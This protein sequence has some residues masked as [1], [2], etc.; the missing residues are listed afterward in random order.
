MSYLIDEQKKTTTIQQK[1]QL[2]GNK[3]LLYLSS[4]RCTLFPMRY[5]ALFR[6]VRSSY[7][8]SSFFFIMVGFIFLSLMYIFVIEEIKMYDKN[9]MWVT[10]EEQ[11]IKL[12]EALIYPGT[13]KKNLFIMDRKKERNG[14]PFSFIFFINNKI[15]KNK[16]FLILLRCEMM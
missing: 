3:N 13:K 16:T 14:K 11:R 5:Y 7:S 2:E 1:I 10:V 4:F 12:P 8:I 9:C 6:Q 15:K